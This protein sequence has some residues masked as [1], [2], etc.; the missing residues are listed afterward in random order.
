MKSITLNGVRYVVTLG[1]TYDEFIE[2]PE[3]RGLK[4][5]RELYVDARLKGKQIHLDRLIHAG[6]HAMS[7]ASPE[8]WVETTATQVAR[9][10]WRAGYR[11]KE[12]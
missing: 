3:R 4:K 2:V 11:L 7:P 1:E 10:L 9:L 5:R 12:D 6:L 8:P